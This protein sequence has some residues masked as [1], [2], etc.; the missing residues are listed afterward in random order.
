MF[1][2][3]EPSVCVKAILRG[4]FHALIHR[5]T[6]GMLGN[7]NVVRHVG[8]L[9]RSFAQEIESRFDQ[10]DFGIRS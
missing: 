3:T 5:Q 4:T 8:F 6:M 7:T 9:T 2:L 1:F 10:L